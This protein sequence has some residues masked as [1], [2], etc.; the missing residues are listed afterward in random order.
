MPRAWRS[1][2]RLVLTLLAIVAVLAVILAV[3]TARFTSRQVVVV[4]T[5]RT[6][7]EAQ[8]LAARLSR[9]IQLR[10]ILHEDPSQVD[11][12]G[13]HAIEK[14]IGEVFPGVLVAPRLMIGASDSRHYA[15]ITDNTYRLIPTVLTAEDVTRIHGIDERIGVENYAD[16]VRFFT[17]LM[18]NAAGGESD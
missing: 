10:T 2:K 12:D 9:A 1:A 3:N 16:V 13:F 8:E 6:E 7:R 4:P 14:T 15:E 17:R 5:D 18:Q 11:S